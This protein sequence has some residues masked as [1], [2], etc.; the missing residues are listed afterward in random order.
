MNKTLLVCAGGNESF[1]NALG[2]G[3]GLINA[4]IN[5]SAYLA[6]LQS[7]VMPSK[8]VFIGTCGLYDTKSELL[9]IIKSQNALNIEISA[10]LDM[11]YS[12]LFSLHDLPQNSCSLPRDSINSSNYITKDE[13]IALR[14]A[15]LGLVAEN[16]E[17]YAICE[18]AKAYNLSCQG[19]LCA[20]NYCDKNAHESFAKNHKKAKDIL[21]NY[22][23]Q[24]DEMFIRL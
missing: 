11:S 17:F 12:P 22:I 18:V 2:V 16:M 15:K 7:Y 5:L 23:K 1:K 8:I 14:F 3:V 6:R 13:N 9:S 10:L 19:V 4:S 21:K 24:A 20:T